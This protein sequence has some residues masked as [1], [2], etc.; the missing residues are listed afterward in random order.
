MKIL[1]LCKKFPFPPKDGES[2][3]VTYLSKALVEDGCEIT[4]LSMNTSKH[5]VNLQSVHNS[6][7]HYSEV[8]TVE[9][10]N[11][12]NIWGAMKNL[13]STKSYHVSRFESQDFERKLSQV[14]KNN[15]FDMILME[16]LYLAPYLDV[17]RQYSDALVVMRAHN[18]EHEIWE[19]LS[20]NLQFL[21]KKLY[22]KYLATKLKRF[23]I[24]ML[25]KYDFLVPISDVDLM[26]FRKL[27][28][29]NGA[30]AIPIG[31]DMNAYIP[32]KIDKTQKLTMS[33]IGSM[34][35]LPNL[36]GIMWFINNIWPTLYDEF[37]HLE[38]H[39]AGRKVPVDL[40]QKASDRLYVHGEV[41]DA[42]EFINEHSVMLV[43]L[44]SGSGMRAKILEGM[45]LGRVVLTTS[46][47]LEGIPADNHEN[48][49]IA[50]TLDQFRAAIQDLYSSPDLIQEI[51]GSARKY[52]SKT[53]D[54]SFL[55]D[56]LLSAIKDYKAKKTEK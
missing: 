16:T 34:D 35:W 25:N 3:A 8:H 27:G 51:S 4:L 30:H 33:F 50:D 40:S 26:K 48:V 54:N 39:I 45:A 46:L 47:G 7:D 23:E 12:V 9:V 28:Y 20:R 2:I 42:R 52:V 19:Q 36:E 1:Q 21:P 44:L 32:N 5:Y 11:A 49:I 43:P 31:L 24:D 41:R 10:D 22:L 13:F 56:E 6:L 29:L 18:V 15:E 37:P 38:L 55:A 53:Y 14:L 17:I